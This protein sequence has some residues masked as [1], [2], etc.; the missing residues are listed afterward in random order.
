M[1]CPSASPTSPLVP[2][3]VARIDSRDVEP[4][5]LFVCVA[6][7]SLDGHDF[8]E[9]ALGRGAVLSVAARPVAGPHVVV[10]DVVEALATLAGAVLARRPAVSVVGI[11][12]SSGKTSTKDLLAQVLE[13]AGPTVSPPGS[14]NNDLGLPLTVLRTTDDTRYLVLEMGARGVGHIARLCVTAPPSVGV[15]LNVGAAHLGE[16]GDRATTALAKGE[17]VEALGAEGTA[18]LNADDP[19]VAPMAARTAATVLTFGRSPHADVRAED[20][21]LDR[22]GRASFTLVAPDGRAKVALQVVGAHQVANALAAAAAATALGVPPATVARTLSD[23]RARSPWRME[24]V[25]SAA[26]V[27]VVN[28]AYNANPESVAAALDALAVLGADR[29]TWAVLGEMRELGAEADQAHREVGRRAVEAGVDRLVVVGDRAAGIAAGALAAGADPEDVLTAADA[30]AAADLLG[31]SVNAGDVVLVKASRAVGLE[32][33]ADG[34]AA[35][36]E[37]RR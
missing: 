19:Y 20:V 18:V 36:G 31:R 26:G 11:T 13:A 33:V 30:A 7:D 12:G 29:R 14:F 23:A 9:Q 16:F 1:P 25:E 2:A 24:V 15:V 28:D 34:L 10:D 32:V 22:G 35:Q 8:V 27:T 21:V 37:V 6:G 5:D 4:G 3:G 17:L